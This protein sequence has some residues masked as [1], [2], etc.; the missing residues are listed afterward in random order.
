MSK[1]Y[2]NN[3]SNEHHLEH[4]ED[5]HQVP[6]RPRLNRLDRST[7]TSQQ[8]NEVRPNRF[9]QGLTK[10]SESQNDE[11][12][13]KSSMNGR[14]MNVL[15]RLG[16]EQDKKQAERDEYRELMRRYIYQRKEKPEI[17]QLPVQPDSV[18]MSNPLS[19]PDLSGKVIEPD[20]TKVE[21]SLSS[22]FD[23]IV[24]EVKKE[25]N[26]WKKKDIK[27]IME[28]NKDK[29]VISTIPNKS[30]TKPVVMADTISVIV[31]FT[32]LYTDL[33]KNS[34]VDKEKEDELISLVDEDGFT[35]VSKPKKKTIY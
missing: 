23:E 28:N 25:S 5:L 34:P 2:N 30:P 11:N 27:T 33:L 13:T 18:D 17:K 20:S 10:L 32:T 16:K 12:H 31:D 6:N 19:F 14:D 24:I 26:P 22:V 35:R 15:F 7:V 8:T 29:K 9:A 3:T 21:D 1:E 4:N